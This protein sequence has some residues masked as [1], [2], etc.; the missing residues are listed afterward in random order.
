MKI[1]RCKKNIAVRYAAFGLV[2]LTAMVY[3]FATVD[4]EAYMA[5]KYSMA[6]LIGG[7]LFSILYTLKGFT[8]RLKIKKDEI[9]FWDGLADVRH[10]KYENIASIEYHPLLRIRFVMRDR[11][12]TV[13]SIPNLFTEEEAEE[14]LNIIAKH[15]WIK[16]ERVKDPK[17]KKKLIVKSDKHE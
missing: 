7:L 15:K 10:I 9:F 8:A 16:I 3:L 4:I 17:E 14:M 12:K 5:N 13:F 1:Y 6:F 11:K 2:L